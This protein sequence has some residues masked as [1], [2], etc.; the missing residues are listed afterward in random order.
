MYLYKALLS[1]NLK[2]L[3]WTISEYFNTFLRKINNEVFITLTVQVLNANIS[4]ITSKALKHV[5]EDTVIFLIALNVIE[6]IT[7]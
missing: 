3:F 6:N 7:V 2:N 5:N 4:H 1:I